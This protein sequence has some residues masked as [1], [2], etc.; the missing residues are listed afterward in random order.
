M[1]HDT[2]PGTRLNTIS[3]TFKTTTNHLD[4][5]PSSVLVLETT[6]NHLDL[7][8]GKSSSLAY[9]S[10]HSPTAQTTHKLACDEPTDIQIRNEHLVEAHLD[11][12]LQRKNLPPEKTK[13][14]KAK[15]RE[16]VDRFVQRGRVRLDDDV[17]D[18][19]VGLV[20]H[21]IEESSREKQV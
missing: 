18:A 19:L 6:T 17:Y 13:D 8:R 21:I 9:T 10:E 11:A 5:A 1:P 16:Y 15:T 2:A 7:V 12:I 14:I 3:C 4:S 20:I